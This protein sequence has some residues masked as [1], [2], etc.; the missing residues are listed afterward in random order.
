MV[1]ISCAD[2]ICLPS[3]YK[4][5]KTGKWNVQFAIGTSFHIWNRVIMT[6]EQRVIFVELIDRNHE[7]QV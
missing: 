4:N 2:C 7:I 3:E 6:L 1:E 5:S